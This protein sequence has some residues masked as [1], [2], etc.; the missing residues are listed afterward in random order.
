MHFLRAFAFKALLPSLVFLPLCAGRASGIFFRSDGLGMRS[1]VC[2]RKCRCCK[3]FFRPDYRNGYHQKYCQAEACCRASKAAS[4]RRWLS[5]AAN[6]DYFRGLENMRRVQEWRKRHPQYWRRQSS[7]SQQGA[8]SSKSATKP[9]QSSCNAR[10]QCS[11]A[12]QD[13]CLSQDPVV[14]GLISMVTGSTLQEDIASTARRLQARG[15]DILGLNSAGN[16]PSPH[17]YQTSDS[18]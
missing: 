12:L 3:V 9:D 7:R 8:S 6:R 4:Q 16:S 13:V 10:A 18:S 1:R 15:R 14:I 5:K 11:S 17:D 2:R